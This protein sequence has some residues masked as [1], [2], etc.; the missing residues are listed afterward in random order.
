[1]TQPN[2]GDDGPQILTK[3]RAVARSHADSFRAQ[4]N[5][6]HE[7]LG[8]AHKYSSGVFREGLIREFL[9]GVL[10]KGVSVDSGFIYGFDQ[11]ENSKQID[12][13][14]WDSLRHG[15]VYRT[16][17]FVII[18]PESVIAAISVKTTLNRQDIVT[19]L[20]NLLSVV[21][22]ELMY[23]SGLDRQS[24]EPLFRPIMKIVVSYEGPT[25]S[26]AALNTISNF[27]QDLFAKDAKLAAEMIAA[28][29]NFD[30]IQ[31]SRTQ[32]YQVERVL[33]TLVAAIETDNTSFLQGWGPPEHKISPRTHGPG[34]RRLPYMYP[35]ENKLTSPLE[36]LVYYVLTS[37]YATLGT[38]GCS[39]VA[40]WGE[41]QPATGWR[42]GDAS[43]L[44]EQRGV[45]LLD[46][47]RLAAAGAV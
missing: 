1:M 37:A 2:L 38:L 41:F 40:A 10:P 12:I 11:I 4:R 9:T 36:K 16:R 7:L 28:F 45:R 44:I 17:E 32:I 23:R 30:P 33:P 25:N 20:E 21:P 43:E 5:H 35:Q 46:P 15:A 27:F 14:V 34:L 39:L 13:L 18:P 6:I 26:E 47:D 3:F 24:T 22:L 8:G 29:Q 31:P 42:V 19:S